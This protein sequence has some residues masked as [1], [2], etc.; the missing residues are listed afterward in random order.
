MD[1]NYQDEYQKLLTPGIVNCLCML[2][3]YKGRQDHILE[4]N[5]VNL[6]KIQEQARLQS[7]KSSNRMEG[8]TAGESQLKKLAADKAN[9]HEEKERKIAGYRDAWVKIYRKKDPLSF[10]PDAISE[11]HKDLYRWFWI[12]GVGS[13]RK[14]DRISLSESSKIKTNLQIFPF[15]R[16][17]EKMDQ[18]CEAFEESQN[19]GF[20]PL[21]LIPMVVLNFLQVR[22]FTEGNER[23]SRLLIHLLLVQNGFCVGRYSSLEKRIEESSESYYDAIASAASDPHKGSIDYAPF[24]LYLLR[25]ISEAC[26]DFTERISIMGGSDLSKPDQ[27]RETIRQFKGEFTKAE[28]A[29]RC[30]NISGKTMQRAFEMLIK[31]KTII[32]ISGGWNTTY[33]WNGELQ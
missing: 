5:E 3:E 23:M 18:L 9:P 22:P 32:K 27:V 1:F 30:P 25:I 20:D 19:E 14:T 21:L 26:R 29:S 16:I 6:E 10:T 12:Q 2:H 28:I 31:T 7:I 24:T 8:I 33:K 4:G 11:L 17:P 15:E 13:Y